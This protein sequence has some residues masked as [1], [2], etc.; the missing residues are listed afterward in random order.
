MAARRMPDRQW[1]SSFTIVS[2]IPRLGRLQLILKEKPDS[3]WTRIVLKRKVV[4][5][6]LVSIAG[7]HFLYDSDISGQGRRRRHITVDA[8][9]VAGLITWRLLRWCHGK[10]LLLSQGS[11][12]SM[13]CARLAYI[14][15][16]L[17]GCGAVFRVLLAKPVAQRQPHRAVLGV[18]HTDFAESRL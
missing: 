12:D 9:A 11:C 3:A 2:L 4:P 8:H 5:D 6:G 14:D 18:N 17:L 1:R 10:L 13:R 16:A 7:N 15:R